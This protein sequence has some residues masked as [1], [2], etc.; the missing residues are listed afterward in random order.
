MSISTLGIVNSDNLIEIAAFAQ[1]YASNKYEQSWNNFIDTTHSKLVEL[2]K[3]DNHSK[4]TFS[5]DQFKREAELYLLNLRRPLSSIELSDLNS[6][7]TDY[8]DKLSDD[9]N[10]PDIVYNKG[11]LNLIMNSKRSGFGFKEPSL[12][13][14]NLMFYDK[15]NSFD[16]LGSKFISSSII[17]TYSTPEQFKNVIFLVQMDILIIRM[18]SMVIL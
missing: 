8:V 4:N 5:K 10:Y 7:I 3:E 11:Y 18:N 1:Q 15:D 9:F 13:I 12:E 16:K 14:K 17:L 6:R 2:F